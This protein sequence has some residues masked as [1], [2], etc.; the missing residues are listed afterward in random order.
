MSPNLLSDNKTNAFIQN[1]CFVHP[2]VCVDYNHVPRMKICLKMIG[3]CSPTLWWRFQE[4]S[5]HSTNLCLPGVG[6]KIIIQMKMSPKARSSHEY[7]HVANH[8]VLGQEPGQSDQLGQVVVHLVLANSPSN[9]P[10]LATT[11]T[12]QS[13]RGYIEHI[14]QGFKFICFVT[15]EEAIWFLFFQN[16]TRLSVLRLEPMIVQL[17]HCFPVGGNVLDNHRSVSK[18]I[19]A[20]IS[21]LIDFD[22]RI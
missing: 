22:D 5:L 7:P 20:I 9:I 2:E 3:T 14:F 19:S 18:C 6:V 21:F 8:G 4:P 13:F 15:F 12:S 10:G 17:L 11:V 1:I 16:I